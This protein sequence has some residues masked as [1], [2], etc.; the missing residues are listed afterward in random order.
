MYASTAIRILWSAWRTSN[1][2]KR[3]DLLRALGAVSVAWGALRL[4]PF[5]RV[6]AASMPAP[7]YRADRRGRRRIVEAVALVSHALMPERPCLPQSLATRYLLAR[8]GFSTDLQIGV[9]RTEAA[10]SAHAWLECDGRPLIEDDADAAFARLYP[11][12]THDDK[13]RKGN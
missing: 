13:A 3:R 9:K 7:R 2:T 12:V 6:V 8:A 5:Q 11:P 10:L 1:W 4:F